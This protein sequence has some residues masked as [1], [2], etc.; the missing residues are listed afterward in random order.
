MWTYQWQKQ[1]LDPCTPW[2]QF[3]SFSYSFQEIVDRMI[4][5]RPL[6][7]VGTVVCDKFWGVLLSQNC[8]ARQKTER[9]GAI[10]SKV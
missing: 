1:I 7:W 8:V 9:V 4:C 5:L 3:S 10:E 6:L 2:A